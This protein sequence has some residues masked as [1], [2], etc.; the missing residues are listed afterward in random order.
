MLTSDNQ[1]K[2][3]VDLLAEAMERIGRPAPTVASMRAHLEDAGFVD[4]HV[5]SY[6]QPFGPWPKDKRLKHVGAMALL[7]LQTGTCGHGEMETK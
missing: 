5:H 6:K 2:R 7:M 4:I 3:A 1:A